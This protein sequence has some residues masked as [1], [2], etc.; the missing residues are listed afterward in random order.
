MNFPPYRLVPFEPR[1]RD[2]LIGLVARC[3]V[4]YGQVIELDS[5]DEDLLV[6]EEKYA[7]PESDFRVLLD[8]DR[9]IGSVAFRGDE[10][11][12]AELKRVF[13]DVEYRG[14]GLG[15]KLSL[16]AFDAAREARI[17][18]LDIWSDTL[19]ETAHHLY[20]GL[21]AKETGQKRYLG[22]R[23]EVTEIHFQKELDP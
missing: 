5:L 7:S 12:R 15:K 2:A 22:G 10:E 11:G 9:L 19:F 23:N 17:T 21:G 4:D 13:L 20:R 1:H 8:G 3:Y 14:R 6:I 18:V 16:W